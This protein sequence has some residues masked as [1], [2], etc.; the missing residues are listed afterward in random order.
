MKLKAT[1]KSDVALQALR[2][3]A[4]SSVVL[5][6]K[7]VAARL[8]VSTVLLSQSLKPLVEAGWVT[9]RSGP[10]GGY[11]LTT[12]LKKVSVLD[13]IEAVE[14][15]IISS[16]CVNSDR[17]CGIDP[18]CSMHQIWATTRT[19]LRKSLSQQSAI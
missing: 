5:S 1:K 15:P 16:E 17:R 7:E 14:G 10:D 12:G 4:D 18:P 8:K 2:M 3:F 6:G 13:V 9:S 11:I 19:A